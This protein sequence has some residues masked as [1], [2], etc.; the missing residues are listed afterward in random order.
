M[1]KINGTPLILDKIR[2]LELNYTL[3]NASEGNPSNGP[4]DDESANEEDMD[5]EERREILG[6]ISE[7]SPTLNARGTSEDVDMT[8]TSES[9][10][11]DTTEHQ[12]V[13]CHCHYIVRFLLT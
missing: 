13:S 7:G 12:N 5:E 4:Q 6:P 1:K 2:Y 9:I 3:Y 11:F 8:G 10:N